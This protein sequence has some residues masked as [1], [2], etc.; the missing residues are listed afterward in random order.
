MLYPDFNEL[1]KLKAKVA[2]I[3]LPTNSSHNML[4][5]DYASLFHG[6]GMEFEAV[7]NY[8]TG[9]DIRHID[10]R[11]SARTGK[12]HIKTFRAERDKQVLV[13]VDVNA[14]MRFGTRGTF[15]SIQAARAAAILA[16]RILYNQDRFGGLLFGEV[17]NGLL[18]FPPSRHQSTVWK[19]LKALCNTATTIQ[20][21][22]TIVSALQ[23]LLK[24]APAQSLLFIISDFA[25][26]N[27]NSLAKPLADLRRKCHLVLLPVSDI[28]DRELPAIGAWLCKNTDNQQTL[29]HSNDQ[30]ARVAYNKDWLAYQQQLIAMTRR[31]NIPMI[32]LDTNKDVIMDV[33]QGLR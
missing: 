26:Y 13:I 9:D 6:L 5:G 1:I 22:V 19:L 14:T 16:W 21:A 15:K 28:A 33:L 24:V 18:Y 10:W 30:A 23:Y 2:S 4:L 32:W 8:V 20:Q 29:I 27:I 31:L 17:A 12:A 3:K 25:L 7:R 11:V